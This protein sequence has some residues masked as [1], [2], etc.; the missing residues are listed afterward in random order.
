MMWSA[1]LPMSAYGRRL[2]DDPCD[3]KL[4]S[5]ESALAWQPSAAMSSCT[6]I[7]VSGSPLGEAG[8]S[9]L[10]PV[11]SRASV[12]ESLDLSHMALGDNGVRTLTKALTGAPYRVFSQ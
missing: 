4:G 9:K 5:P 6:V 7:K 1:L 3:V 11:L 8:G 2:L 10:S 12:L